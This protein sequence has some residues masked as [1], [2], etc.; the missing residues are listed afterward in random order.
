MPGLDD[1]PPKTEIVLIEAAETINTKQVTRHNLLLVWSIIKSLQL[2]QYFCY[3]CL[4]ICRLPYIH[5]ISLCLLWDR[6]V[7]LDCNYG[8][9]VIT[10]CGVIF[11]SCESEPEFVSLIFAYFRLTYQ[12]NIIKK[13]NKK[14]SSNSIFEWVNPSGRKKGPTNLRS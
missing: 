8:N 13:L 9:S 6:D 2:Y 7:E 11:G 14:K 1:P 3:K 12:P 10:L 5:I 4:C